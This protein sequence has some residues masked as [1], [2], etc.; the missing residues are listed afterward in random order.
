MRRVG[1]E[2]CECC[3]DGILTDLVRDVNHERHYRTY[4]SARCVGV[5]GV[6]ET[7]DS[8]WDTT[9]ATCSVSRL[10]YSW[11]KARRCVGFEGC[12]DF[13]DVI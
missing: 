9:L 1:F 13:S 5:A 4:M 10:S 8:V 11:R 7:K 2:G 12:M 6:P 3:S